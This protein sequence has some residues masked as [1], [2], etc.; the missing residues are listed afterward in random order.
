MLI[1]FFLN[2]QREKLL[3]LETIRQHRWLKIQETARTNY[4]NINKN[5]T[6]MFI[7]LVC[8]HF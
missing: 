1:C 2:I 8:H 3:L 5:Q 4:M 7:M 6:L